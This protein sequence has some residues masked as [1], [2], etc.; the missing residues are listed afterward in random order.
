MI[1]PR[2][3][4]AAATPYVAYLVS[5]FHQ[6]PHQD[7][8][9]NGVLQY[10]SKGNDPH[11]F[12]P[13]NGG[14]PVLTFNFS[15][16]AARDPFVIQSPSKDQAWTLVTDQDINVNSWYEAAFHGSTS[17]TVWSGTD[18]ADWSEAWALK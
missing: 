18:L 1:I 15:H 6:Q 10:L 17:I 14:K 9:F 3:A 16:K 13:L 8:S 11:N 4:L 5:T 7:P 12:I 2:A